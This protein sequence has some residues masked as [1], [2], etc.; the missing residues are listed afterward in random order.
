M[1]DCDLISQAMKEI[2]RVRA[3]PLG[4][5][6]FKREPAIEVLLEVLT[7]PQAATISDYRAIGW[8]SPEK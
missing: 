2:Q 8:H 5:N 3:N 1:A 4:L 7:K 6:P